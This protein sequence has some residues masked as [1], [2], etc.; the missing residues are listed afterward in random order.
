MAG[1]GGGPGGRRGAEERARGGRGAS[2]ALP[3]GWGGRR[4]RAG[5]GRVGGGQAAASGG[6]RRAP[7]A[8]AAPGRQPERALGAAA[9]AAAARG[10]LEPQ[11]P[12]RCARMAAASAPVPAAR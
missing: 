4:P 7:P 11:I 9:A 12:E 2:P 10:R 1:E 8:H 6:G 3:G 5:W